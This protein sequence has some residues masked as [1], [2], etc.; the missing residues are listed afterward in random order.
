MDCYFEFSEKFVRERIIG[1]G[2]L[3]GQPRLRGG[4]PYQ[5]TFSP[6]DSGSDFRR[7]LKR[8]GRNRG[9]RRRRGEDARVHPRRAAHHRRGEHAGFEK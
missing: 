1:D 5:R 6:G 8:T 4:V 7:R 2:R 9:R 3:G